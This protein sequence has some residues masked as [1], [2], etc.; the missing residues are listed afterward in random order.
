MDHLL[1]MHFV[2]KAELVASMLSQ[3]YYT[4][5]IDGS[6]DTGISKMN[7]LTVRLYDSQHGLI[8]TQLLD[9]CLRIKAWT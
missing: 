6:S 1:H 7:P 2:F 3:L 5:A 8:V 9:M 4:L